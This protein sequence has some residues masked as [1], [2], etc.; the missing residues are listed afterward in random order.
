[1]MFKIKNVS[2]G[3]ILMSDI[4]L[5]LK[6]HQEIDLDSILARQSSEA[7][8]HLKKAITK[9]LIEVVQKDVVQNHS[10][11]ELE[12]K[13]ELQCQII[14]KLLEK[15]NTT[16]QPSIDAKLESII[17]ALHKG[18]P[19]QA[20]VEEDLYVIDDDKQIDIDKRSIERLTQNIE[21]RVEAKKDRLASDIDKKTNELEDLLG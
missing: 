15:V 20:K 19:Q 9:G 8:S 6:Q 7:S 3:S 5:I 4:N 13:L 11:E 1:M 21:S 18:V 10:L 12:K 16:N 17:S 2:K 14:E